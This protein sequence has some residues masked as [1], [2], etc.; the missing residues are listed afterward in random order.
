MRG[1]ILILLISALSMMGLGLSDVSW[2]R[3]DGNGN[4]WV[5]VQL[6]DGT[7]SQIQ[8]DAEDTNPGSIDVTELQ[9]LGN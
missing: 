5:G 8:L 9:Q 1:M 4:I 7:Q 2:V 6:Q 3:T